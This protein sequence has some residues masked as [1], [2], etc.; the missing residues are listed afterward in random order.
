MVMRYVLIVSFLVISGLT[1]C[2]RAETFIDETRRFEAAGKGLQFS[3]DTVPKEIHKLIVNFYAPDCP[4]CE[5]EIPALKKFYEKYRTQTSVGFV[6]VGSSLKAVEQNPRP[7]KDPPLTREQILSELAAFNVK[8]SPPWP[9]YLADS[10][11]L[12]T[13]RITGFPETF[14]FERRNGRWVLQKKI[15]SEISFEILEKF[16]LNA[17]QGESGGSG[18]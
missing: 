14:L 11:D 10:T 6:A 17:A 15:I 5:K 2:K 16:V 4:P 3:L 9:Q 18:Y 8:Y 13:W 1:G 12:K 7:G